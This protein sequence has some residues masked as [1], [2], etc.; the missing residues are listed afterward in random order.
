MATLS[1]NNN[2]SNKRIIRRDTYMQLQLS[3]LPQGIL[4]KVASYLSNTSCVSFA[5]SM[6]SD[7]FSHEPSAISTAI[8]N[9]SVE[10]WEIV[11]FKD[12]QDIFGRSLTDDDVR[13]ILLANDGVNK[14]K[15]LKLTSCLGITGS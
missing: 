1:N 3:D 5:M 14:I 6:T 12:M 9:A 7:L 8:I 11:D 2:G 15:S 13:W 10:G 4:P